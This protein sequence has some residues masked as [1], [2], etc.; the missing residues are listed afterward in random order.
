MLIGLAALMA[1]ALGACGDGSIGDAPN[2]STGH[3]EDAAGLSI[4]ENTATVLR[5]SLLNEA[6]KLSFVVLTPASGPA[7]MTIQINGK[8]L[9]IYRDGDAVI[10]DG[11]NQ[12]FSTA[13]H[14]LLTGLV[15]QLTARFLGVEPPVGVEAIVSMAAFLSRAPAG[16]VH[17]RDVFPDAPVAEFAP[18]AAIGGEGVICIT[19]NVTRNAE[20]DDKYG[21]PFSTPV[22]VGANWG[23]NKCNSGGN[24]SCM[25]GCGAGCDSYGR[26]RYTK[27]CLD[28]DTCS[29]EY[30]STT[31]GSDANCG[32]EYNEAKDDV[33]ANL[34][35]FSTPKCPKQ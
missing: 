8:I 12:I 27:D 10:H 5:G 15:E 32:D 16:Y 18:S 35:I 7:S 4:E 24:Y 26:A 21:A 25:G 3:T 1:G 20:Y 29:H 28:H 14:A 30:C 31:G 23:T 33:S 22:V 13:D 6:G 9:E 2:V 34:G 19:K 17:R 11:H